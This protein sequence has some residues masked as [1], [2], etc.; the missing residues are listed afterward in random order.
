MDHAQKLTFRNVAARATRKPGEA[1]VARLRPEASG[2]KPPT[3]LLEP[4]MSDFISRRSVLAFLGLGV[5]GSATPS[6]LTA[7]VEAQE[8]PMPTTGTERRVDR[9][10]D[11]T[12]RRQNRRISRVERRRTRH[13]GRMGR[14]SVRQ[15]GRA[16]RREVRQG[17]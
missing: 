3:N 17:M 5:L 7:S 9:R 4:L 10:V 6:L 14:R 1:G 8:A 16:I 2:G 11:R 15:E 12:E 13:E